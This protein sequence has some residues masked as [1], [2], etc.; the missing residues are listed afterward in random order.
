MK[1]EKKS[2][3][4][5]GKDKIDTNEVKGGKNTVAQ[6]RTFD[7]REETDPIKG[8]IQPYNLKS[9]RTSDQK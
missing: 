1:S 4:N 8:K 6:E 3:G 5:L 2:I 9:Q 7:Y